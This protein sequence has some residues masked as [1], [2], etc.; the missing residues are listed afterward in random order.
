MS[1]KKKI[2]SLNSNLFDEVNND[3]DVSTLTIEGLVDILKDNKSFIL[4]QD[5][6][7]FIRFVG[8]ENGSLAVNLQSGYPRDIIKNLN[9]FFAENK[10]QITVNQSTELG[11]D[12]LEQKEKVL[13]Q[14]QLDS[15]KANPI[16]SEVLERF[17]NSVVANI[18]NI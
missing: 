15:V 17:E 18:E 10:Y 8:F 9:S 14:E 12:T 11:E 4:S 16:L 13:F 6:R 2:T 3:N 1:F 7:R 5:V